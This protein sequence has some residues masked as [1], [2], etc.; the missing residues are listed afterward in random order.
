VAHPPAG[1]PAGLLP[2]GAGPTEGWPYDSDGIH[3]QAEASCWITSAN[4]TT[5]SVLFVFKFIFSFKEVQYV[6]FL[7]YCSL[8]IG[9]TTIVE[10]FFS[11]ASRLS[12]YFD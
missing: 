6:T 3:H 5:V 11:S 8:Q 4:A 12:Y 10:D 9:S 7:K 1:C 2:E